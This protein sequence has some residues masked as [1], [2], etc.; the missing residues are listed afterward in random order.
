MT[1][2]TD[3]DLTRLGWDATWQAAVAGDSVVARVVVEHRGAYH[4]AGAGGAGWAELPGRTFHRARDKRDL[5]TVG[6]W[7]VVERWPA[8]V[9]G[10]GAA[11]IRAILPRRTLIVRKAAGERT[12]PQPVAAN[13]DLGLIVTSANLD[14]SPRRLERYLSLLV[15]AGVTPILVVN[16][17]DLVPDPGA[18]LAPVHSIAGQV[19]V[20]A[21]SCR[22][23]DGL[24]A[25]RARL[26]RATA[27]LLGS[28]G[29]G[30]STLTNRLLGRDAQLTQ[31]QRADD[32]KGRHT[33]TR[34]ELVALDD[35]GVLIDTPG[36]RELGLWAEGDGDGD[37]EVASFDDVEAVAATCRFTDCRHDAEPGCAVVA[38]VVAGALPADR[39]ASF[40]KLVDEKGG[41][42]A[43]ASVARRA[44]ERRASRALR[45]V[46]RRKRGD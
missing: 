16:K 17:L 24:T 9:A 5:P 33:T 31:E 11:V 21:T 14:L 26:G 44:E 38:A 3:P 18:A 4:V 41:A 35:G 13:V 42:S 1:A 8:A 7:V 43:R 27:V 2:G 10:A 28:S 30:K 34:R 29:V 37:D 45:D 19:E 40:R 15:D 20:V 25:L 12:T 39:V 23:G 36:M 32:D 6:D 46:V 22:T